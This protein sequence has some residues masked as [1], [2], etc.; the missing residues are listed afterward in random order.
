MTLEHK[1]LRAALRKIYKLSRY[2]RDH[3]VLL[4]DFKK[5]GIIASDMMDLI[6][7]YN[8]RKQRK[9]YMAQG[10]YGPGSRR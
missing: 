6:E 7:E 10:L 1:K 8:H 4:N 2:K 9:G 5:I 3:D